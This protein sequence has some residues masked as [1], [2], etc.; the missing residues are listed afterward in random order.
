MTASPVLLVATKEATVTGDAS[1]LLSM[2]LED[3]LNVPVVTASR[4]QQRAGDAPAKVYTFPRETLQLRGYLY[5][6]DLLEDV[7]EFEVNRF[8]D[9]DAHDLVSARGLWRNNRLVLTSNL[10][11][12]RESPKIF[13]FG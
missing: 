7:P 8:A 13:W 11:R 5:L 10:Y 1:S 6:I 4:S 2:S 12:S 3:L 9:P